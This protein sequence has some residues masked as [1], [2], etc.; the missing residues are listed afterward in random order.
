M[1][2]DR[3]SSTWR[4]SAVLFSLS[5]F[6]KNTPKNIIK[7]VKTRIIP[8]VVWFFQYKDAVPLAAGSIGLSPAG[9][10]VRFLKF[11]KNYPPNRLN[12]I[13][14]GRFLQTIYFPTLRPFNI[15]V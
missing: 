4:C 10:E 12:K 7:A 1:A 13:D 2:G 3:S 5:A 8:V 14:L 9:T 11:S 6:Q 15:N